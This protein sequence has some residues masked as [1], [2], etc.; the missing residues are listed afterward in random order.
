[1]INPTN[2]NI[3]IKEEGRRERERTNNIS[4]KQNQKKKKKGKKNYP[5]FILGVHSFQ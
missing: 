1:M 2:K 4:A 3:E 5:A